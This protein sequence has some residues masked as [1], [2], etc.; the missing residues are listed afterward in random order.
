MN[1]D[2]LWQQRDLHLGHL[3]GPILRDIARNESASYEWRKEAVRLLLEK[4]LPEA[5]HPDLSLFVSEIRGEQEARSEVVAVV[6]SAI[7]AP[8]DGTQLTG[9]PS[10]DNQMVPDTA[11]VSKSQKKR[12]AVQSAGPFTA[13][14]T[15]ATMFQDEVVR[16]VDND[17]YVSTPTEEAK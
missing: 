12:K 2:L 17:P 14:V 7:E 3:P 16:K 13:S 11:L 9:D 1:S 15:T 5:G 6:E 4:K 10:R 8:L